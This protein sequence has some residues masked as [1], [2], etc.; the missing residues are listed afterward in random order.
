M[1][2]SIVNFCPYCMKNLY[3]S[4]EAQLGGKMFSRR[5][6]HGLRAFFDHFNVNFGIYAGNED[7]INHRSIIHP[8][9]SECSEHVDSPLFEEIA[10]R[11]LIMNF[12]G[13]NDYRKVMLAMCN[14]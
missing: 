5:G 2:A 13:I 6:L 12:R 9:C 4:V 3:S 7:L 1:K 8:I 14:E 10:E 11:N